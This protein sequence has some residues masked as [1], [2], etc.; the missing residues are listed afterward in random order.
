VRSSRGAFL[1]GAAAI[2][3]TY[4]SP[5]RAQTPSLIPIRVASTASDSYAGALYAH[6]QGFFARAG[7]DAD[8]QIL[9][10]G[11][12]ITAAVAAKAIDIG[13]TNAVPLIA[14]VQRGI[15]FRYICS[16]GLVNYDEFGMCVATSSPITTWRDLEGKTVAASSLNDIAVL[17]TRSLVDQQGGDSTKIRFLE[18][19]FSQM[20][21]F[22]RRGTVDAGPIAEP[23]LSAAKKEGGIRVIQ[24]A[25]FSAFGPRFMVGGWFAPDDWITANRSAA[26]RFV[27]AI[28]AAAAWANSHPDES[29]AILAKY[30]KIDFATLR[31]MNRS[32]LG[33]SLTPDMLQSVLD[34]SYKYKFSDRQFKAAELIARV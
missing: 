32:P 23:A 3:A 26:H 19:P 28:Y 33:T 16:G 31:S 27:D 6:D 34:L 24:P 11:A 18:V 30:S 20:A 14:A 10:S 9:A 17:A 29:S 22:I 2:A 7:L 1:A 12:A 8:V 4:A 15:Q 5:L 25:I 13:I 21:A